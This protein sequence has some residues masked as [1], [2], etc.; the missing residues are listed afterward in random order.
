[1]GHHSQI[2]NWAG[3]HT[4]QLGPPY[5]WIGA[6]DNVGMQVCSNNLYITKIKYSKQSISLYHRFFN[7]KLTLLNFYIFP[8]CWILFFSIAAFTKASSSIFYRFLTW[9]FWFLY[10]FL[11]PT[12]SWLFFSLLTIILSIFLLLYGLQKIKK[13]RNLILYSTNRYVIWKIKLWH[14]HR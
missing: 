12:P 8:I 5:R 1:M 7:P 2:L 4:A 13:S 9:I 6:A 14:I 11:E 10:G 3:C